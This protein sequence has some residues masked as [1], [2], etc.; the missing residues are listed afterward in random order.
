MFFFPQDTQQQAMKTFENMTKKN[1][2]KFLGWRK[3]P[4]QEDILGQKAKEC[5]PCIMQ[6]FIEKNNNQK[7][8]DF[9]RILY[10]LLYTSHSGDSISVYPPQKIKSEIKEVIVD[11]TKRL[12]KA[13]HVIGLI[14][15]QFIVYE[16]QVYAVS[17]THLL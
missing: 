12:A 10:C 14:N 4:C 3:V 17:Y 5:M 11:Y 2:L 1:Q 13:L 7:K 15:I 6:C 9:E 16:D 8:M